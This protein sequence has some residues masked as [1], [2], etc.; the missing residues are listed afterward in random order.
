MQAITGERPA[1]P[2]RL[3]GLLSAKERITTIDNDIGAA[4]GIVEK[5]TRAVLE[6]R[7]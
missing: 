6:Q 2:A 7:G 5:L 1:L 3:D 4:E